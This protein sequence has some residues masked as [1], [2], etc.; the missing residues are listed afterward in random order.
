VGRRYAFLVFLLLAAHGCAPR[1]DEPSLARSRRV[2]LRVGERVPDASEREI[3]GSIV[4]P[5]TPGTPDFG[6]LVRCDDPRIV[7]KDEEE[8]GDDRLMTPRL[9][10]RLV[11]LSA[12]VRQRWPGVSLRVT[13]AWDRDREHGASSLHYEGRAAD[14]TTSDMDPGKLGELSWLAVDAGI[15]WVFFENQAHVHLSVTR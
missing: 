8:S 13:E 1:T 2:A 11:A 14:V 6:R 3:A 9:R 12:L 7:F 5:V 4:R 15:D 10:G